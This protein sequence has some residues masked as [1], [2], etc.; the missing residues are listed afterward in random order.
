MDD[1]PVVVV[2]AGRHRPHEIIF[3]VVGLVVGVAYLLGTPPAVSLH[4]ALPGGWLRVWAAAFAFH[5]LLG[6]VAVIWPTRWSLK[7]EQAAQLLGAGVL[8]WYIGAVIPFGWPALFAGML[9]AA[10]AL[11]NL[12]RARQIQTELRRR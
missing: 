4:R 3:L 2:V 6:L 12:W 7:L 5:G 1:R 8:V 9:P 10:W 11:A